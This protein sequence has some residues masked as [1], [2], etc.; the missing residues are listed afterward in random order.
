MIT[1]IIIEDEKHCIARLQQ[2]LRNFSDKIRVKG[3]YDSVAESLVGIKRI[4]PDLIFMDVELKDGDCF[5]LLKKIKNPS[6]EII[7]TTAHHK[8]AIDA[9]NYAAIHY[10][11][12]PIDSEQFNESVRRC[13][14]KMNYQQTNLRLESMIHNI[15]THSFQEKQIVFPSI[16]DHCFHK[17]GE[18]LRLQAEGNY[19]SVKLLNGKF[20]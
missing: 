4:K 16:K 3:E 5:D 9:F 2:L 7:F 1:A 14:E 15:V 11:L 17:P 20:F 6:F 19:C 8:Y 13:L 18:I 12:K 10:L